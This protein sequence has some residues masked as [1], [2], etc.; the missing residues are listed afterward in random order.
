MG[1]TWGERLRR[2]PL[3][4]YTGG[5][6]RIQPLRA[7]DGPGF[8]SYWVENTSPKEGNVCLVGQK[9]RLGRGP[10]GQVTGNQSGLVK[11]VCEHSC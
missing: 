11:N 10:R 1:Q 3:G 5:G 8:L 9:A 4:L 6:G 7:A 2:L